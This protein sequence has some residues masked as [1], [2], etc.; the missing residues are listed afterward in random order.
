MVILIV[1]IGFIVTHA[2]LLTRKMDFG[3]M[4]SLGYSTGQ[5]V[6]QQVAAFMLYVA[7]GSVLGSIFL[8]AGSNVMIAGLFRGMGVYRITFDF[9]ALW[10]AGLILGMEAVGGITAFVSAWKIRKIAPCSLINAEN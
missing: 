9:P 1:I 2:I 6:A 4:K 8:Y 7:G 5:L 3:I 10:I